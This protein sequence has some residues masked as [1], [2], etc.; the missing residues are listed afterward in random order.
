[1]ACHILRPRKESTEEEFKENARALCAAVAAEVE[2][3][4]DTPLQA[5]VVAG[6]RTRRFLKAFARDYEIR[7]INKA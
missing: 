2:F 1:M 4:T 3:P 6:G 5:R 7:V